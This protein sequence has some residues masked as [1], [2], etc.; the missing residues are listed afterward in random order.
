MMTV[1]S[2]LA[3]VGKKPLLFQL[4]AR[5]INIYYIQDY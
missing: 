4:Y 5:T 1:G 3:A 2:T